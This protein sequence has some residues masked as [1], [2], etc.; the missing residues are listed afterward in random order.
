LRIG[1]PTYGHWVAVTLTS[2]GKQLFVPRGFAHGF[3]TLEANTIVAYKTDGYYAPECEQGIAWD[4]PTLSIG[5]PVLPVGV[6][7][8]DKDRNL[9]RFAEFISPFRY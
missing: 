7:I 9:G 8:S 5:W 2:I 3:C 4:D 6:I 1:S